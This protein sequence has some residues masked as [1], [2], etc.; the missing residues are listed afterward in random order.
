MLVEEFD[1]KAALA[2]CP[3]PRCAVKGIQEAT[4]EDSLAASDGDRHIPLISIEPSVY[5]KCPSCGLVMEWP[6]CAE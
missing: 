5:A 3:C 4:Y 6:G 1:L 2:A